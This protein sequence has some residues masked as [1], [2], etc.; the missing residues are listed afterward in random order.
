MNFTVSESRLHS[1]V[2]LF[3]ILWTVSYWAPLSVEFSKQV[4]WSG[5]PFPSPGDLPDPRTE[6]RSAAPQADSLPTEPLSP[7]IL[8]L[9]PG[10]TT[11]MLHPSHH[12]EDTCFKDTKDLLTFS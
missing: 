11:V 6:P 1:R 4:Y 9:K 8:Y 10:C 3:V 7:L 2:L 12:K 5:L